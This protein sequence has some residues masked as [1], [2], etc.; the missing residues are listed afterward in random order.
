MRI[1][2]ATT[3]TQSGG[4]WHHVLH[5]ASG[6]VARGHEVRL[7][8]PELATSLQRQARERGLPVVPLRRSIRQTDIWHLHLHDTYD[9]RA[10]ALLALRGLTGPAIVTE[11][12]PHFNGSDPELLREGGR[13]ALTKPL[14]TVLKRASLAT[15]DAVVIPSLHVSRFY[16]DRYRLADHPRVCVVPLG[17]PEQPQPTAFPKQDV[18]VVLASG[19]MIVQKGFDLLLDAMDVAE[20][21]WPLTILGEGPH[22]KA[23]EARVNGSTGDRVVFPG[24][25]SNPLSWLGGARVFCLPSRWETFPIAAIEA[26][27]AARP[28]VAFAVDG[29]PEIVEHGVTGL[30][31]EPGDIRGLARALDQLALDE[32]TAA[33]MGR[34]GRER[35][36]EQFGLDLMVTRM[37]GVYR[38]I[39]A[40]PGRSEEV[41]D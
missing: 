18:G 13:T 38:D 25:Q 4:S 41:H 30:L 39:L 14:K 23:L 20:V 33:E 8:L 40:A 36:L 7:S 29:V 10:S 34:R 21:D 31:A 37:E 12:L 3:A 27:L 22:R 1:T 26:Q 5:L 32:V 15:S 11:H 9:A 35:A 19:S 6:L 16:R 28:V 2:L 24:W 17:I